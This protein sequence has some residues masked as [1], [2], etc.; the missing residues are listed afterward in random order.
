MFI[1][2]LEAEDNLRMS[3]KFLDQNSDD[4]MG[5][6]LEFNEQC[7]WEYLSFLGQF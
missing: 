5:K 4:K 6:E 3:K 1:D 7:E 2:S